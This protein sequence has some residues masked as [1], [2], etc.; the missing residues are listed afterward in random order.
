VDPDNRR[1][2]DFEKRISF[3]HGIRDK[4]R[5]DMSGLTRELC[6]RMQDG[7]IKL[8]LINRVLRAR[9]EYCGVF[10]GGT[11]EPLEVGGQRKEH[12]I[13]FSRYHDKQWAVTVAPR[14][15]TALCNEGELPFGQQTWGD[16]SIILP[17]DSPTW[18]EDAITQR[19]IEGNE[20]L[21]VGNI[22]RHF[23]VALIMSKEDT[24]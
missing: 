4:A 20:T 8:F 23:P 17:K 24:C 21:P 14:F 12:I 18:W 9:Q 19:S 10:Q 6:S 11:Y 16:T 13:A 1:P 15:F 5:T 22:I 3:L 2:V 7:R